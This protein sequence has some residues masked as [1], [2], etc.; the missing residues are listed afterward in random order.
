MDVPFEG[1]FD[2]TSVRGTITLC[3]LQGTRDFEIWKEA[4]G[5]HGWWGNRDVR[6]TFD[7]PR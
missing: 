4:D 3:P 6:M 2:G 5:Y 1:Q 7:P